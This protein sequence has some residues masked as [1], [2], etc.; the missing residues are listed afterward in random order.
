MRRALWPLLV[1]LAL[2]GVVGCSSCSRK[3]AAA[4]HVSALKGGFASVDAL[5][6]GYQQALEQ[7]DAELLKKLLLAPED[8]GK[9]RPNAEHQ[10]WQ[11]YFMTAK[12]AFLD[13]NK[14]LLGQKLELVGYQ[15]GPLFSKPESKIHIYRGTIVR[16]KLPGGKI[17]NSEINFLMEAAGTWKILGLK[18]LK[19]EMKRRG[20]LDGLGLEGTPKFHGVDTIHDMNIRVRKMPP[21]AAPPPPPPAP[22]PDGQ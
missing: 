21:S 8:L 6:A 22:A 7:K 16:F 4:Q 1:L 13:H 9:I 17:V 12:Q 5:V 18:Y 3:P 14:D 10:L 15:L 19:E 11:W 2:A 20:I